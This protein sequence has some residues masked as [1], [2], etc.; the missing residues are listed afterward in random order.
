MGIFPNRDEKKKH[1]GTFVGTTTYYI[2]EP[3]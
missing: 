2:V 1:I 3:F